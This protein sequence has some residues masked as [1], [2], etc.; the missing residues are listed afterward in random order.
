[1]SDRVSLT[2]TRPVEAHGETLDTLTFRPPVAADLGA[3]GMPFRLMDGGALDISVANII[4][5]AA[6]LAGVPPS[7]IGN[8]PLDEY[9]RVQA[10]IMGFFPGTQAPEVA[11]TRPPQI[12]T[13]EPRELDTSSTQSIGSE[14]AS[15]SRGSGA[16]ARQS[17]SISAGRN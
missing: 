15:I 12:A 16:P 9:Y 7:V 10:A 17:S 13:M 3:C 4:A 2:L 11:T 6:R 5:L 8:M 14:R 1:M